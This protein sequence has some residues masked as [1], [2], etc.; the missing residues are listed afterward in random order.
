VLRPQILTSIDMTARF[1]LAADVLSRLSR[2]LILR[3]I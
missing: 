2:S 1:Y 3:G